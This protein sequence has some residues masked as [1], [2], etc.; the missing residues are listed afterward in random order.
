MKI[1]NIDEINLILSDFPNF[2]LSYETIIHNKVYNSDLILAIPEGKQVF[3]WFTIY[4]NENVCFLLELS[5]NKN[6]EN[7]HIILAC[8]DDYLCIYPGTIL[9]G[10]MFKLN[11]NTNNIN[12]KISNI[13]CVCI[14]DIYYYKGNKIINKNYCEK[15]HIFKNIFNNNILQ[16]ILTNNMMLF[17]LPLI[18]TNFNNLLMDIKLL[19]YKIDYIKFRFTSKQQSNSILC[20][21]YVDIKN[22]YN[23]YNQNNNYNQNITKA[24]FKVTPDIQ[25]DVYNLYIFKNGKEEF[26]DVAFIPDYKTSVMM[27][28]LFRNIKENRNLDLLEESDSEEEFENENS[29]KFVYLDKTYKMNCVFNNKFKKWIPVSVSNKDDRI[30][31][32]NTLYN[33]KYKN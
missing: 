24:I 29:S 30:I 32:Y 15:L 19:P 23:K 16:C 10:K 7:I 31:S 28:K 6:V 3:I 11:N 9:Y 5:Q 25:N 18:N 26:Y 8:F 22:S 13:K 21:K 27:N 4:K 20:L 1:T 33:N 12:N 14:E 17:G 2:E